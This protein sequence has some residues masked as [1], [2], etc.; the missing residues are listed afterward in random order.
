MHETT[1]TR[2]AQALKRLGKTRAERL[3]KLPGVSAR[4]LQYWEQEQKMPIHLTELEQAGVITIN[5]PD[6]PEEQAA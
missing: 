5:T 6:A 2:L 1:A 3:A 4:T